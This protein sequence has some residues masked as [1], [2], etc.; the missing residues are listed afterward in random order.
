ME[1]VPASKEGRC[2]FEA[3]LTDEGLK[4]RTIESYLAGVWHLHIE[5]RVADL[6]EKPLHRL[7]YTL[8]EVKRC[9]GEHGEAT[10][11]RLPISPE[12]YEECRMRR[13]PARIR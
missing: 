13:E 9:E 7:H 12:H 5:E 8:R 1:A 3:K 6:F 2:R 11:E 4:H 10:R